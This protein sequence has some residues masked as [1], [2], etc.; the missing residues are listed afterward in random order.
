MLEG[1]YAFFGKNNFFCK[2]SD[3]SSKLSGRNRDRSSTINYLPLLSN[4]N[5]S[6]LSL[7]QL[8]SRQ[9]NVLLLKLFFTT[10]INSAAHVPVT[11]A[12]CTKKRHLNPSNKK[13]VTFL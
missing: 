4:C 5:S 10:W 3:F 7:L 9:G 13:I 6:I 11:V 1:F 8:Q 2:F 12:I